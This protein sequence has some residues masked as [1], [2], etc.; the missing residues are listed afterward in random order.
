M[1]TTISRDNPLASTGWRVEANKPVRYA[2]EQ[3]LG[4]PL[5][6]SWQPKASAALERAAAAVDKG[7]IPPARQSQRGR[8]RTRRH[9]KKQ[10]KTRRHRRN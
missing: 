10:K 2:Q 6:K 9:S 7:E 8:K 1:S 5:D 3:S 4:K